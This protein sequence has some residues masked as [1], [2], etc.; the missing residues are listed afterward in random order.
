MTALSEETATILKTSV[1]NELRPAL[2]R[3]LNPVMHFPHLKSKYILNRDDEEIISSIP[4]SR[5]KVD[6]LI[7]ILVQKGEKGFDELVRSI[8]KDRTQ[9]FLAQKLNQA[10]EEKQKRLQAIEM[11]LRLS[12]REDQQRSM[13]LRLSQ[14]P[15]EH[16][17]SPEPLAEPPSLKPV[18]T[19]QT[20][21][22]EKI[23]SG[24]FR[25]SISD[26]GVD[27]DKLPKPVMPLIGLLTDKEKDEELKKAEQSLKEDSFDEGSDDFDKNKVVI[28]EVV[29]GNE[30]KA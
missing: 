21:S 20:G 9:L 1:L 6:K 25:S 30:S 19:P 2:C 11:D 4:I 29:D 17:N 27:T 7:D 28:I 14:G 22:H 16:C 23:K 15:V 3:D 24:E 26:L 18:Y 12:Q 5:Q 8:V 13:S 10:Y